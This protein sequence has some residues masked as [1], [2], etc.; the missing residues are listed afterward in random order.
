MEQMKKDSDPYLCML[1]DRRFKKGG[2]KF[3]CKALIQH[4]PTTFIKRSSSMRKNSRP[5]YTKND[6]FQTFSHSQFR[7]AGI[8]AALLALS[9]TTLASPITVLSEIDFNASQSLWGPNG[10]AIDFHKSGSVGNNN[11]GVSFDA[12]AS[13]GTV[14]AKYNGTLQVEVENQ[15][16]DFLDI[17]FIG[18]NNGGSIKTLLGASLRADAYARGK[19]EIPWLPDITVDKT[20]N[21]INQ[22][23]GLAIDTSFTPSL[24][25][26]VKGTSDELTVAVADVD[27]VPF[28]VEVG[29]EANIDQHMTFKGSSISGQL[30]NDRTNVARAFEIALDN[31][32]ARVPLIFG[33]EG[34][35][36]FSLTN[37]RLN[38]FFSTGFDLSLDPFFTIPTKTVDFE[39]AHFD[40]YDTPSFGLNFNEIDNALSFSVH[41]TPNGIVPEPGSLILLSL[42]LAGLGVMR[43]NL[44]RQ[45]LA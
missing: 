17:R 13:T 38:N 7:T 11:F 3:T 16:P 27:I 21:I 32:S 40:L 23:Y 9:S 26:E 42:G 22:T 39:V 1:P 5:H 31:N 20:K 6:G 34:D 37:L 10:S 36:T 8:F 30:V 19:I 44:Q 18:D 25:Q 14:D 43:W 4:L 33:F 28:L 35:Y 41:V 2:L 15:D 45:A 29:V 12:R 24:G